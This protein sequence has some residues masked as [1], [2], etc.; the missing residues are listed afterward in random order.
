MKKLLL[1][2]VAL[3][4]IP[5]AAS[6]GETIK[7]RTI[8]HHA[9]PTSEQKVG[10]VDG[11]RLLLAHNTGLASFSDGSVGAAS[12]VSIADARKESTHWPITYINLTASDGS[13]LRLLAVTDSTP[14]PG[15]LKFTGT[16]TVQNSTGHF[17]GT[18]GDGSVVGEFFA[19]TADSYFDFVVTLGDNSGTAEEAKAMLL[20]TAA[21]IKADRELTLNQISRGEGGFKQ[22]DIYPFCNRLSDGKALASPPIAVPVGADT[23]HLKDANGKDFGVEMF[24]AWAKP[25]GV[26]TAIEYQFPKPG[27]TAPSFPKESFLVKV[28]P[29][30]GCG[31]G[32]YK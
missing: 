13:V 20:K 21:A 1:A 6:A 17:A 14:A 22:G 4:A 7:F 3:L 31:V 24:A 32:F 12:F 8:L 29:D 26:I 19:A 16:V 30:L 10:D 25:E 2:T 11:H 5:I 18:K 28:A 23:R 9:E 27:T 15:K